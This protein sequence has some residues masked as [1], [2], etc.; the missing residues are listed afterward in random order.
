MMHDV[1]WALAEGQ[2]CSYPFTVL[3]VLIPKES[4]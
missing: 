2:A 3:N 4:S 1:H